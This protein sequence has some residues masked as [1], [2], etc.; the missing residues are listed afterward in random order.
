MS[1]VR[2]SACTS[3]SG[4]AIPANG[5]MASGTGCS[6]FKVAGLP[7]AE[8]TQPTRE[9]ITTTAR[10]A[11]RP[12]PPSFRSHLVMGSNLNGQHIPAPP[13]TSTESILPEEIQQTSKNYVVI[14]TPVTFCATV[15]LLSLDFLT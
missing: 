14:F 10:T 5:G 13:D 4:T 8:R 7:N 2:P 1:A 6:C 12:Q 9:T 3:I 11:A 15:T